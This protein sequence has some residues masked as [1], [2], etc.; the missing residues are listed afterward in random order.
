MTVRI[1]SDIH[2]GAEPSFAT[3]NRKK[4]L[5]ELLRSWQGG[6]AVLLVGDI[7]EFWMEYRDYIAKEHFDFLCALRE[8]AQS[9]TEVHYLAGNHDFELGSFFSDSLGILCHPTGQADFEFFG[10]KMLIGHGDGWAKSDWKYRIVRKIIR[11]PL[12]GF[13]FRL[14]HP[15]WGMALARYVGSSSREHGMDEKIPFG[16]YE[17]Y[18]QELLKM[19]Y[20]A[21][22]HG[23]LHHRRL[24]KIEQG[25]YAVNGSWLNGLH[26]TEISATGICQK[27]WHQGL[28]QEIAWPT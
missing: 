18:A 17:E 1:L 21:V 6:G 23:H 11:H 3:P 13:A 27:E 5:L 10:K 2:L 22:I 8:L 14:L 16:E 7:F 25:I 24:K 12:S 9:G 28:I 19:D 4:I 15:D 20:S 26:W